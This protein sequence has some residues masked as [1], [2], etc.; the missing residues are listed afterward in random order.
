MD[1]GS[2]DIQAGFTA[3]HHAR[4]ATA[5]ATACHGVDDPIAALVDAAAAATAAVLSLADHVRIISFPLYLYI[6]CIA[7]A[8]VK[9]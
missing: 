4:S 1:H 9:F 8:S 5:V 3:S 6:I 7:R 2:A